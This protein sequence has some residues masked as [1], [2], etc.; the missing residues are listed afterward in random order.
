MQ[1]NSFIP[2][3]TRNRIAMLMGFISLG[4]F[5]TWNCLPIDILYGTKRQTMAAVFWPNIYKNLIS[6]GT[7][8]L[9]F[10]EILVA[11]AYVLLILLALISFSLLPAW[12]LWQASALLRLIPASMMLIGFGVFIYFVTTG[13]EMTRSV[14]AI[15]LCISLNFFTA[16]L[17][18]L[19]FQNESLDAP[20]A[21]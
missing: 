18:L 1:S 20:H 12:K 19:L 3:S 16:A 4:L 8:H 7:L 10:H 15:H 21:T 6:I 5:I 14:M 13:V 2:R 17:A 11:M 9:G